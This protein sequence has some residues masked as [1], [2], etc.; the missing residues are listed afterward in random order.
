MAVDP[1]DEVAVVGSESADERINR[2]QREAEKAG[3]VVDFSAD[4]DEA[5]VDE[6]DKVQQID[7]KQNTRDL[8]D[9]QM[10]QN[11]QRYAQLQAEGDMPVVVYDSVTDVGAI[12]PGPAANRPPDQFVGPPNLVN[13]VDGAE[14]EVVG[15][16]SA[17]D[18]INRQQREAEKAGLVVDFSGDA[19]AAADMDVEAQEQ[20]RKRMLADVVNRSVPAA[21]DEAMQK[22][23]RQDALALGAAERNRDNMQV[24]YEEMRGSGGGGT[25]SDLAAF[26]AGMG[27]IGETRPTLDVKRELLVPNAAPAMPAESSLTEAAAQYTQE[28]FNQQFI[29][30]GSTK[31]A[32]RLARLA[33]SYGSVADYEGNWDNSMGFTDGA[34]EEDPDV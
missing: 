22:R 21:A 3:Q 19:G 26:K 27:E 2:Q 4:G 9:K 31:D 25:L 28:D 14:V 30:Q 12:P 17:D 1:A 23:R 24:Q 13:V 29:D 18:R 11:A 32:D 10:R 16:E 33:E 15:S 6:D 34:M 20:M 5:A 7:Y 8:Y